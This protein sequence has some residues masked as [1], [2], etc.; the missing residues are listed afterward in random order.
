MNSFMESLKKFFS[1]FANL[2]K[3]KKDNDNKTIT[4][5]KVIIEEKKE[6]KFYLPIRADKFKI[7]QDFLEPNPLYTITGHHPGVD[8]GTQ[9]ED[10]VPLYF[11]A[12][13]EVIDTGYNNSCGNYFFYYVKEVDRTFVYFHLR[14]VA[15]SLGFY[16][17]GD[18]CGIT[19][20]T[21]L[22]QGI[23]LHFECIIGKKKLIDRS[24]IYKTKEMI[25]ANAEN[26]NTFILNKVTV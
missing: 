22:S 23:H 7:T 1:D 10:N 24:N 20:K 13:G 25:A 3:T 18:I 5:E 26:A 6:L 14:D 15:P 12:D 9:G 4:D 11:V 8:Y 2:F 16:K 17:G 19:G 21:G